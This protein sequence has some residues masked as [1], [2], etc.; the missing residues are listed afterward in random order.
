MKKSLFIILL[1]LF[2]LGKI[3][4]F[5]CTIFNAS[6]NG[7]VLVG[8]NEDLNSTDSV[9]WFYPPVNG[10][11]GYCYVGF[12][13]YGIQ[14]GMNDQG[15]FFDY[16]A[17][18]F[19][20]M[21]SSPGKLSIKSWRWF[22]DKIMAECS[23]VEDL[24]NLLNQYNLGWWGSNQVM[25]VDAKGE[26]AVIG[27]DKTGKL[28]IVR[29]EGEYQVSTNF[30]LA[31]PEFGAISY[32]CYRY[33]I[34]NEMLKNM[35]ELT[36]DY[37]RKILAA[38]HQEGANPTVYS[39][40]C[41]LTHKEI[42]LYNFH[43]FEEVAKFNLEEEFRKGE[44][45]YEISSLFPRKT[46][47]QKSFEEVQEKKLSHILLKT[48]LEEGIEAAIEKYNQSKAEA[49]FMASELENLIFSLSLKGRIR[50]TIEISKLYTQEF[51]NSLSGHKRLGDIYLKLGNEQKAIESYRR[52]LELDPENGEVKEILKHLRHKNIF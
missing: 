37:F 4:A 29:K 20:K 38:V 32:P 28:S 7:L 24:I 25:F 14:G 1:A 35:K 31:N 34:A 43:N 12:H 42:Y 21:E 27:A 10:K 3:G 8:N 39:N 15:L 50:E 46:H 19:S 9:I 11:Y 13:S 26:S 47:A 40:I 5:S 36:V 2:Y 18:K 23:S 48:I 44:H 41:D 22:I 30:S 33:E 49:S 52:V 17:L 45:S 6:R 16:N 51:P